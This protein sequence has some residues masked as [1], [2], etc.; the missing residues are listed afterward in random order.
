[1]GLTAFSLS[2][3]VFALCT[4][5]ERKS[6]FTLDTLNDRP[7]LVSIGA[8]LAAIVLATTLDPFERLLQTTPLELEHWLVCIAAA[9]VI[10]VVSEVRKAVVRR[11]IDEATTAGARPAETVPRAAAA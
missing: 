11:P 5:D 6:V 2:H 1:M 10:L 9:L 4:K 8:S 7:L 3:I